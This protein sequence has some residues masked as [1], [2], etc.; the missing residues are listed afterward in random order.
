MPLISIAVNLNTTDDLVRALAEMN[1]VKR[2]L[3]AGGLHIKRVIAE[4]PPARPSSRYIRTGTLGRRWTAE[5]SNGGLTVT[6]GNNV[7]YAPLVQAFAYQAFM[8]FG[9]WQTDEDV[10][11]SEADRVT[12]IVDAEVQAEIERFG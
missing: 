12:E 5:P 2:G 4:Y 11:R 7:W 6:V 8:H 3:M 1:A 10:A 9:V